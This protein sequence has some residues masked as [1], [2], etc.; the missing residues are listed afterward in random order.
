MPSA[1]PPG[2]FFAPR[3]DGW[4]RTSMR[5]FTGPLPFS[6]EPHRPQAGAHRFERC[7]AALETACSPRSTLLI[8]FEIRSSKSETNSKHEIRNFFDIRVSSLFRISNFGF[9][10]SRS[11]L[12]LLATHNQQ[13]VSEG[14]RTR[15]LDV[16]SVACH[17]ATPQTPSFGR[18]KA[19]GRRMNKENRNK[20][21]SSSCRFLSSCIPYSSFILHPF[22]APRPG[23]EPGTPS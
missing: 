5:R 15:C 20:G 1:T 7:R 21:K 19:E 12:T 4:I 22:A 9:R 6:I 14:N 17:P 2:R 23:F 16:H 10:I 13:R 18:M 3:A 11:Q 8:K